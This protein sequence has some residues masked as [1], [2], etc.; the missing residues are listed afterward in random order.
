MLHVLKKS[1]ARLQHPLVNTVPNGE[2][3]DLRQRL[4]SI[5]LTLKYTLSMLESSNRTWILQIQQ[6]RQFSERF[7]EAYPTTEDDTFQVARH[8]AEESQALYDQ[9]TRNIYEPGNAPVYEHIHS[10]LRAYIIEIENVE[11]TYAALHAAKSETARYQGKLDAMG[12][13]RR[14]MD[15]SK[16]QRNEHKL[17]AV[18]DEYR[19][20]L[21][22]TVDLQKK[23]YLKYPVMFKAALTAYWLS[24]E[25]HVNALVH[26]LE[27]TQAFAK[28]YE[29]EMGQLDVANLKADDLTRMATV[30]MSLLNGF[31]PGLSLESAKRRSS[32]SIADDIGVRDAQLITPTS[33]AEGASSR[34][35]DAI[36]DDEFKDVQNSDDKIVPNLNEEHKNQPSPIS[37]TDDASG[38]TWSPLSGGGNALSPIVKKSSKRVPS[39]DNPI[40]VPTQS[41]PEL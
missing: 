38:V 3:A 17:D 6:Q 21:K 7:H 20:N 26:S 33:A 24:H 8:F 32:S 36:V 9:F 28:A 2:Y 29:E 40:I 5:K 1:L 22:D 11:A 15:T 30:D 16:R 19:R 37:V 14:P 23:S 12:R 10:Q 27:R 31:G 35:S 25:K 4:Y 41:A 18:R 13:S 34:R 39:P